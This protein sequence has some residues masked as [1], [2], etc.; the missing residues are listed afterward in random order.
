LTPQYSFAFDYF[1]G[2][3]PDRDFADLSNIIFSNGQLDPWNAG[4]VNT[5]V[6][7]DVTIIYIEQAAHHLDLRLPNATADPASVVAARQLEL[8]TI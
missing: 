5:Q 8:A 4:G 7:P 3:N 2:L 6:S 1:G